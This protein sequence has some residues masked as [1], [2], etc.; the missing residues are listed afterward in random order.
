[1]THDDVSGGSRRRFLKLAVIA[2]LAGCIPEEEAEPT[3]ESPTPAGP[4]PISEEPVSAG[5][6][7]DLAEGD[8]VPIE[9][10]RLAV[11]RDGEGIWAVSTQCTHLG[12][13]ISNRSTNG[14]IDFA[15]LQCGCHGSVYDR[16][17]HVEVGPSVRD[18][19]NYA[20][21]IDGSGEVW[22]DMTEPVPTGT[23]TTVT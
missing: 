16:D 5:Q 12:C 1:M 20:V 11:G 13:D 14:Q 19:R 17:G 8:L 4:G 22:V 6:A 7:D 2:P 21:S 15:G 9:G 3:P 18:L 23:R 10:F